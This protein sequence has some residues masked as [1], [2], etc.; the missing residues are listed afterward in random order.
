MTAKWTR[1]GACAL[2]LGALA[3]GTPA[4][5]KITLRIGTVLAPTDP[6]DR[7]LQKFKADVEAATKGPVKIEVFHN[8]QLGDTTEMID[9]ARAG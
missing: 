3:A 2:V 1:L 7:G 6:M 9:Q 5:A 8:S 4:L